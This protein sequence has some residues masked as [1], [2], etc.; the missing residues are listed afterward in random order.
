MTKLTKQR[1]PS[2][3]K[4]SKRKPSRRKPSRRKPSRRKSVIK[5]GV[6]PG[7]H[8][9][10]AGYGNHAQQPYK[11]PAPTQNQLLISENAKLKQD[12]QEI[13]QKY[14]DLKGLV[15]QFNQDTH[16]TK[17]DRDLDPQAMTQKYIGL[18]NL[19]MPFNRKS[20]QL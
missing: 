16:Y 6:K 2:R 14:K 7:A 4:Q 11:A 3:R 9:P 8:D 17:F 5:G 18:L 13:E 20:Q 19:V 15:T 12:F 10:F 1:K